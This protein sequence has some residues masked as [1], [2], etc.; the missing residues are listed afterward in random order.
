L[1]NIPGVNGVALADDL[2]FSNNGGMASF[3]IKGRTIPANE[4]GPH[5][6]V[7]YISPD[8]FSTLGIPLLRGRTFTAQDR[9]KTEP[10]A[11]IDT[12]LAR[13]YWP[14]EDPIGQHINF[15]GNSPWMTIVGIV[16]HAKSSSLEADKKE[17]FYFLPLAQSAQPAG[18]IAVRTGSAHPEN[19]LAAI[20]AAIHRVDPSLPLYDIKTMEQRVDSSLVGRRFLVVLLSTFAGL[21]LL[22]AAIGLYGVISYSV[23]L[24]TRELGIRVALGAD[25]DDVLHMILGQGV[26][27]AGLGLGLGL[28]ATL[29]AGRALSSLLYNVSLFNPLT[30]LLTSALLIVT[31][32]LASYLPAHWATKVEPMVA[33]RDE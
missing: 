2:P 8:Y 13:Q 15:Y 17:G 16:A 32:L 12:V 33:L 27:L 19:L 26:R 4:P 20:Q 5:G 9:D 28:L 30:F 14:N 22:L 1:K 21:A 31:V 7:R 29:I 10:V 23:R 3:L 11:I 25:R 6:S 24:R 18:E